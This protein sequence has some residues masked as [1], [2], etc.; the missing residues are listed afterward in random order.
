MIRSILSLT[1]VAV[2]L[3]AASVASAQ[4]PGTPG[5]PA[6]SATPAG[7]PVP[8]IIVLLGHED[9]QSRGRFIF[10]FRKG[11]IVERIDASN[12]STTGTVQSQGNR[13]TFTFADCVYEGND[14]NN[15]FAGAA[16]FTSGPNAGITWNFFMQYQVD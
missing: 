7:R 5:A 15:T 10:I 4:T 11:G 14:V 1:L 12:R 9:L 6:A 13:V 8:E 3:V 16:R 2:S